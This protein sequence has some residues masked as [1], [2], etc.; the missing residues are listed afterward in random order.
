MDITGFLEECY[1]LEFQELVVKLKD[2][3]I[4]EFIKGKFVS[5]SEYIHNDTTAKKIA[6]A[7]LIA[8]F[9]VR[10]FQDIQG[11]H[12]RL[13]Y[14]MSIDLIELL[15]QNPTMSG[16]LIDATDYLLAFDSWQTYDR[17]LQERK[18]KHNI[19]IL[20]NHFIQENLQSNKELLQY[21]IQINLS[22][23]KVIIG[24]EKLS[25]FWNLVCMD[26]YNSVHG[27]NVHF[28]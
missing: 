11:E 2:P 18:Y 16:L 22:K 15:K 6:T 3:I 12:E 25:Q 24:E 23:L 5:N 28:P 8:R 4:I 17:D 26:D 27:L 20:L 10:V 1:T 7:L 21:A 13:L 9:R 19:I 14:R